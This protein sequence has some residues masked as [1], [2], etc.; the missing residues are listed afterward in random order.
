MVVN[1][2]NSKK[3]SNLTL[4]AKV[5]GQLWLTDIDDS[6][7]IRQL[8]SIEALDGT[9]VAKANKKVKILSEKGPIDCCPLSESIFLKLKI[10]GS[11]ERIILFTE[12]VD[13]TRQVLKKLTISEGTLLSI[14]RENNNISYDNPFVSSHH[15]DLAF[16]GEKWS[17]KDQGSLNGT[18]VNSRRI[19]NYVL[20]PGDMIYIMGLKIVVGSNFLALNNP[21]KNVKIRSDALN[22]YNPPAIT[23]RKD[24]KEIP[25]KSYFSRSPRF[26]R[27]IT[28]ESITID[29]PPQPQKIDS[30]PL[31]LMLGP[32]LTMGMTSVSTG[33]LTVTN[34]I[35]NYS[36]Y[37]T[38]V[39]NCAVY[40]VYADSY[41]DT[42]VSIGSE[43][44]SITIGSS[45][46]D[47]EA[48]VPDDFD[49]HEGSY[50]HSYNYSE[51]K[52]RNFSVSI[53]VDK[54]TGKVSTISV[55]CKTWKY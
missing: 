19:D 25:E 9:W 12:P 3:I 28:N 15:A 4:P 54:E 5:K 11:N 35:A 48:I 21:D 18:Y 10:E 16:D 13:Q 1:I 52:E 24:I 53:S 39:E 32:S 30:V 44:K 50:S 49:H 2:I 33:I 37:Q 6:E 34:T 47:V 26:H 22:I 27:E 38:T 42:K 43:S 8:I 20:S 55:S 36:E 7:K 46:A 51:Y 29:P 31:A 40:E 41:G 17:I 14:G 23:P 45:K